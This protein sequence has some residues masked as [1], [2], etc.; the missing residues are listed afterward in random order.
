MKVVVL[1]SKGM[2]GSQCASYLKGRGVETVEFNEKFQ[3]I[4]YKEYLCKLESLKPD[5]V[6]NCVGKIPQKDSQLNDYYNSNVALPMALSELQENITIVHASTDCVFEP[7]NPNNSISNGQTSA[8]DEYG[9]SKAIGDSI[10]K[11]RP[12][13]YILRVSIIGV[14]DGNYSNGLIDWFI[15]QKGSVIDGYCNHFWNGI[16]TLRWAQFVYERFIGTTD[17]R[18]LSS[19]THLGCSE[20]IS[21][22]D[23]LNMANDILGLGVEINSL[24]TEQPVDRCLVV[25]IEL[26]NIKDQLRDLKID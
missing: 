10:L 2:L 18:S 14:T 17:F 21:K 4:S 26:G 23:L 11:G 20:K 15:R 13:T 5:L 12:N 22:F 9:L 19:V 7:N 8:S 16:T 6:I 24:N 1:G 3:R 25:D